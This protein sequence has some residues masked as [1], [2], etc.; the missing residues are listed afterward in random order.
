[1]RNEVVTPPRTIM[2]VFKMLPEGTLAEVIE[3]TLYM[4]PTPSTKHQRLITLLLTQIHKYVSDN[5]L[6]EVFPAP[7]D[8]FLDEQSNAVQ[9][10]ILFISKQNISILD[11]NGTVK[12]IPDFIIEI[13]SPGSRKHD[14]VTK[15]NLYE[16]SGVKEYWIVDP[17]TR[18]ATGFALKNNTYQLIR[19]EE[20]NITSPLMGTFFSF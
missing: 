6:G 11:D 8:V 17:D 10:D 18:K 9:P 7:L 15:K 19:E 16:K 12:G 14:Q 2:E 20:G 13:L 5:S 1:M 4:S 3:N